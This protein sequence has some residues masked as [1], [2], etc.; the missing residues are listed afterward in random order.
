MIRR[1]PKSTL[2]PY[3][4][5]FR[6]EEPDA[7]LVLEVL[8]GD[9]EEGRQEGRAQERA[10]ML[11]GVAQPE[12]P[13]RGDAVQEAGRLIRSEEHT[14]ELQSRHISYAVFCLKKKKTSTD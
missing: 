3:T 5:L 10:V 8:G 13:G 14:S 7:G 6:S 4:T 11:E 9:G 1:P 12:Q 2:F